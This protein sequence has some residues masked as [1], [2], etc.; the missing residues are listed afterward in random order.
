MVI[1][2]RLLYD[3]NYI[4]FLFPAANRRNF[5]FTEGE[6]NRAF[7]VIV[8]STK[9]CLALKFNARK[10]SKKPSG[11]EKARPRSSFLSRTQNSPFLIVYFNTQKSS[12]FS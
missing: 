5:F 8:S 10:L 3:N 11:E 4:T 1:L 6:K 12:F 2:I 7:A 9:N